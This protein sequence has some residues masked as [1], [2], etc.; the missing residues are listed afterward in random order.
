MIHVDR[1]L[2][3]IVLHAASCRHETFASQYLGNRQVVDAIVRQFVT[4]KIDTDLIVLQSE[5]AH[6]TH[7]LN[8][9]QRVDEGVHVVIQFTIGL[10][11]RLHRQQQG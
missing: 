9:A 1:R 8:H 3:V 11:L 4:I 7:A 6:L 2:V 5:D 10:I